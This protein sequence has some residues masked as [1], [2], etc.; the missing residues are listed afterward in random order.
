MAQRRECGQIGV[1]EPGRDLAGMQG[2]LPR[3]LR[4]VGL[5]RAQQRRHQHIA[6]GRA[7]EVHPDHALAAAQP[8]TGVGHLP[9]HHRTERHPE[10]AARGFGPLTCLDV[11]L[12]CRLPR[13]QRVVVEADQ[14]GR[15]CQ[16][17]QV[18]GTK[19]VG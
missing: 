6:G 7:V 1:A 5:E 19:L 16:P 8:P 12:V 17:V 9:M 4:I 2:Q 18:R 10:R 3:S 13:R 14:V 15:H 11:S